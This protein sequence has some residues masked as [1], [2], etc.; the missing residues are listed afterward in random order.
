M[1][2]RGAAAIG[3]GELHVLAIAEDPCESELAEYL[4]GLELPDQGS[5]RADRR[6]RIVERGKGVAVELEPVRCARPVGVRAD[7]HARFVDRAK[8]RR[9]GPGKIDW[10]VGVDER[11]ASDAHQRCHCEAPHQSVFMSVPLIGL[12]D[13]V[14]AVACIRVRLRQAR[15]DEAEER[16]TKAIDKRRSRAWNCSA[17]RRFGTCVRTTSAGTGARKVGLPGALRGGASTAAADVLA[18]LS[19]LPRWHSRSR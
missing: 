6:A 1:G 16:P 5:V 10:S 7:H 9:D 2:R 13:C 3:R 15:S 14:N 4:A 19:S 8:V 12:V 11:H 17:A 18:G